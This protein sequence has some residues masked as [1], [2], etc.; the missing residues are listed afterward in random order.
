MLNVNS[1]WKD[2]QKPGRLV[3]V[4]GG[5]DDRVYYWTGKVHTWSGMK[6]FLR[7]YEPYNGSFTFGMTEIL[8]L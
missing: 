8:Q 3:K 6:S 2:K 1:I 5:N 7:K 4:V